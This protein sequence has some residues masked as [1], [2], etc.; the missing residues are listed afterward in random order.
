MLLIGSQKAK[1][2]K[3]KAKN[4]ELKVSIAAAACE[5]EDLAQKRFEAL[6]AEIA[7]LSATIQKREVAVVDFGQ[8]VK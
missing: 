5:E 3:L 2:A 6:M 1:I 8:K 7:R 4:A